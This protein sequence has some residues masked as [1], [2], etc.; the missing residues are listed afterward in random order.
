MNVL[1]LFDGMSCGQIALDNLGIKVDNYFASEIDKYAIQIAKKN[2]PNMVHVGDVTKVSYSDYRGCLVVEKD[3]GYIQDIPKSRQ[4]DLL[5]G[6]SPCQGFSFAGKQLNF[7]D[8]RSV[9]FFEFVRLLK[10][11]KP[12]YFLLE[13]VKMKKEYQDVIS[14]YLG[15]EPLLINSSLVSAQTRKRLYWTNIPNV[16]Q[17]EDKGIIL[18]DIIESGCVDDRMMNKNKSHCLTARYA[19]A[20]WWNSIE[21]RQRTMISI[22]EVNGKLRHREATKKGYAEAAEGEGLDLTFPK[23]KTRRGRAMKEKSN[24]LTAASHEMGI[25]IDPSKP[26]PDKSSSEKLSWRKLTPLECERLQT[27]P[28]GYT[29]VMEGGKQKVSNSQRYKMLGNGWTIDVITHILKNI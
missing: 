1:S 20:V 14:K 15:C 3:S 10:E 16:S 7:D 22:E 19:G 29:L 25:V 12:K 26:N 5:I 18:K 23:S 24:C 27:V 4:I 6:G 2:Y 28:D 9:L 13:N 21:R 11:L 17:P 8:P